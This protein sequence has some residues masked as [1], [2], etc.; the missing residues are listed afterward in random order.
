M[1][2][3]DTTLDTTII[4]VSCLTIEY[5]RPSS[6]VGHLLI[7]KPQRISFLSPSFLPSFSPYLLTD[8]LTFL[9]PLP[10]SPH[11]F[12]FSPLF[13]LPS[14]LRSFR[15][16]LPPFLLPYLPS[17][18][19]PPSQT[20]PEHDVLLTPDPYPHFTIKECIEQPEAIARVSTHGTDA[21]CTCC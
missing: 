11:S 1:R 9:P 10:P 5:K 4:Q 17:L 2:A 18:L 6:L 3:S 21:C 7:T 20:A 14:S 16:F 8:A 13:T 12:L 15:L 19:L